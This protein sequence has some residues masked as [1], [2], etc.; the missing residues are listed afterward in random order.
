MSSPAEANSL[1][2]SPPAVSAPPPSFERDISNSLAR[3]TSAL[4]SPGPLSPQQIAVAKEAMGDLQ[5]AIAKQQLVNLKDK[6]ARRKLLGDPSA[7]LA[8]EHLDV[9]SREASEL[10]FEAGGNV[11]VSL[12]KRSLEPSEES[13][14]DVASENELERRMKKGEDKERLEAGKESSLSAGGAA[15][16]ESGA[17][18]ADDF[19]APH[20]SAESV[21]GGE[22]AE[23]DLSNVTVHSTEESD[24]SLII[25][26]SSVDSETRGI[27][28][29][30]PAAAAAAA[31][32]KP[33]E[34]VAQDPRIDFTY[35]E[36]I[37]RNKVYRLD[38]GVI[39][40]IEG[41]D[42]RE[43]VRRH[44]NER[45]TF[46][47]NNQG[48]APEILGYNNYNTQ[49]WLRDLKEDGFLELNK[50]QITDEERPR[51]MEA[52]RNML[53]RL[54]G[55]YQDVQVPSNYAVRREDGGAF[56]IRMYEAGRRKG[57]QTVPDAMFERFEHASHI[58]DFW[59]PKQKKPKKAKAGPQAKKAV[60]PR[61]K[62]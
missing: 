13:F 54:D 34:A 36:A 7:D 18:A 28:P 10:G 21:G 42:E 51:V 19:V 62:R 15:S 56:T 50:A 38:D 35:R 33:A 48:I 9:S 11:D 25:D 41:L 46:L 23:E 8:A 40:V 44:Y 1:L 55:D 4:E 49:V 30:Q 17:G 52:V 16:D 59:G 5:V 37:V 3:A 45:M 22:S 60:P 43:D 29:D 32:A 39:T 57:R 24:I 14:A 26:Q 12:E 2:K 20:D 6:V 58:E 53:R 61:K 47:D 27:L 31:A